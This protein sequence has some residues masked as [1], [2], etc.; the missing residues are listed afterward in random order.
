MICNAPKKFQGRHLLS[1]SDSVWECVSEIPQELNA[2]LTDDIGNAGPNYAGMLQLTDVTAVNLVKEM[3]LYICYRAVDKEVLPP[4]SVV[5]NSTIYEEIQGQLLV[6]G[7]DVCSGNGWLPA[8]LI[9][10]FPIEVWG[11]KETGCDSW[12]ANEFGLFDSES[13]ALKCCATNDKM[14]PEHAPFYPVAVMLSEFD[15]RRCHEA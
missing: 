8:S 12:R 2:F 4:L 9:G 3:G 15:V 13:E 7:W 11:G 6:A 5:P 14:V 10:D 1:A